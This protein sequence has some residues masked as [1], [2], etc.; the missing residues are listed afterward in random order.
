MEKNHGSRQSELTQV[1]EQVVSLFGIAGKA[2][3]L[4][5]S[6]T[7][8]EDGSKETVSWRELSAH[9]F[10]SF[11]ATHGNVVGALRSLLGQGAVRPGQ[12]LR[13]LGIPG[14]EEAL[15]GLGVSDT[16]AALVL[17]LWAWD[18]ARLRMLDAI[19]RGDAR[20]LNQ[21]LETFLFG[22]EADGLGPVEE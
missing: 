16:Q 19:D 17:V 18:A 11:E 5:W 13:P 4:P 15:R 21:H 2:S 6:E 20:S 9:V 22:P 7:V 12:D 10:S 8:K 3:R 14:L 1:L